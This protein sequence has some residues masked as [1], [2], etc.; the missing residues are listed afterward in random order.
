MIKLLSLDAVWPVKSPKKGIKPGQ[1][2]VIPNWMD[3]VFLKDEATIKKT[4]L[5]SKR[6]I[7]KAVNMAGAKSYAELLKESDEP[8]FRILYAGNLGK[9]HSFQTVIKAASL[10]KEDSPDIEFV[11]VGDGANYRALAKQKAKRHLDNIRLLPFQPYH[12]LKEMM[13]SGDLHIVMMPDAAEGLLV[14]CK[15]Y[16]SLAVHRPCL[17]LGPA[18]SEI[19]QVIKDFNTGSIIAQDNAIQLI[20]EIKKYRYDPDYWIAAHQGAQKAAAIFLPRESMQAF[21]KRTRQV[22]GLPESVY[23]HQKKKKKA[24]M[25]KQRNDQKNRRHQHS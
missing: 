4:L 2:T 1:V 15:F 10:L 13:T 23:S 3:S 6:K 20:K 24:P 9:A 5:V 7:K 14:P 16:S 25:V 17:F 11:F 22:A 19:G 12:N 8:K 21:I 18:D